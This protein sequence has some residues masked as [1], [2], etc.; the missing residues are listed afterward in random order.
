MTLVVAALGGNALLRRGQ[1]QT[2]A[3]QAAN[4]AV[5]SRAL[6]AVAHRHGLVVTHG[7]GP[8]VGLLAMRAALLDP[9]NPVPLD[10]LGAET[11]GMI[12]YLLERGLRRELPDVP[13]AALLTQVTVDASD[14]AFVRPTK[15][16]GPVMPEADARRLAA[17]RGWTVAP[18][19]SG[20]RRVVPSPHPRGILELEVLRILVEHGVVLV[21]AGGGGVPVAVG[22][23]GTLDGVEGVVDK[24]RTA[25]LLAREL[26]ADVLVLLTDVAG[27]IEGFGTPE[28]RL[29]SRV[30]PAELRALDLPAGSMAPKAEACAEFVELTGRPAAIGALEDAL[31]VVQ[32]SAGTR[33]VPAD[34]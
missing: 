15:P 12:G 6:A 21:C 5:A 33:V 7:N 14:P 16:I 1:P 30:T 13:V 20:W 9:S 3:V 18:E 8:Q 2:A 32:G 34:G 11:E 28:A 22:P 23:D 26:Q 10:V 24:D 25:A 31:A 4:V 27:V 19:E 17:E 29:L